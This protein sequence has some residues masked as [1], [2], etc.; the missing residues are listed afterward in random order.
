[1]KIDR[2]K[3]TGI[4]LTDAIRAAVEEHVMSLDPMTARFDGASSAD[5]EVG[6]TT[7]HHHTGPF[8]RAE[9]NLSVPGKLL[10]AEAEHED[11]YTALKDAV[12]KL[13]NELAKEKDRHDSARG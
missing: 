1:M 13:H 9:I 6:K 10:R 7:Q 4:E 8:F 2:I 5:V 12:K 3:G 11:L